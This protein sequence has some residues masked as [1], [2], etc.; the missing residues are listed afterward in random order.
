[1]LEIRKKKYEKFESKSVCVSVTF[2]YLQAA[3]RF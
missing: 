1:M 3:E 2:R